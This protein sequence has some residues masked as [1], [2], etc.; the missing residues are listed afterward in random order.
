[1]K[2]IGV[3]MPWGLLISSSLGTDL[4]NTRAVDFGG[5]GC[6]GPIA[7]GLDRSSNV[8]DDRST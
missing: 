8:L 1:M 7:L 4:G 3:K 6:L 2:Q 5:G